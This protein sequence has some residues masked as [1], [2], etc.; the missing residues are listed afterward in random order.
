ML[1][2]LL[3]M[4]LVLSNQ[5]RSRTCSCLQPCSAGPRSVVPTSRTTAPRLTVHRL[6]WV[7]DRH[8][9]FR[10]MLVASLLAIVLLAISQ[11]RM[12]SDVVLFFGGVVALTLA[13]YVVHRFVLHGFAPIAHRLHRAN[14]DDPVLTIFWQIWICFALGCRRQLNAAKSLSMCLK[15]LMVNRVTL[16]ARRS[17]PVF[18]Q[19]ATELRTS[20]VVRFV[21]QLTDMPSLLCFRCA[22]RHTCCDNNKSRNGGSYVKKPQHRIFCRSV[23]RSG[24]DLDLRS[25]SK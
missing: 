17:L 18:A 13:E 3:Q 9:L 5:T 16:T 8:H 4:R 22:G 2:V 6:G 11:F 12:S 14:L 1:S 24:C 21:P 20:L 15:S 19:I 25:C 10:R 7:H 23:P